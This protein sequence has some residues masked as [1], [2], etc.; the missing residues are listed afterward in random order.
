MMRALVASLVINGLCWVVVFTSDLSMSL[1]GH[2]SVCGVVANAGMAHA[3]LF[4]A[5]LGSPT[6]AASSTI[7]SIG[8]LARRGRR[9]ADERRHRCPHCGDDLRAFPRLASRSWQL[10][11]LVLGQAD[12]VRDVPAGAG[13]HQPVR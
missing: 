2:H 12:H 10:Q 3:A 8:V 1:G 6:T 9:L 7:F 5:F 11:H 4:V 13:P